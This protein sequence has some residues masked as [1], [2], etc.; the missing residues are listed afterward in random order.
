MKEH[1]F[2]GSR[3]CTLVFAE[4]IPVDLGLGTSVF[5]IGDRAI[6]QVPYTPGRLRAL[7]TA[8]RTRHIMARLLGGQVWTE[9]HTWEC[10]QSLLDYIHDSRFQEEPIE[11]L[12]VSHG[13]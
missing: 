5:N 3:C 2:T 1:D 12:R 11:R 8:L 9:D 4:P 6:V 13:R 7:A 10:P